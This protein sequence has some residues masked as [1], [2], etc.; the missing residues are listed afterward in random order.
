MNETFSLLYLQAQVSSEDTGENNAEASLS[1]VQEKSTDDSSS[2]QQKKTS[3]ST[4][5]RR[6]SRSSSRDARGGEPVLI[7][8]NNKVE[9]FSMDSHI[10]RMYKQS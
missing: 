4:V 6:S 3:P 2:K 1:K 5:T 9:R 8:Y 7:Q 10:R